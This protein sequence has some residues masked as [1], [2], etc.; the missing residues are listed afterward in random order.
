MTTPVVD[1]FFFSKCIASGFAL[2]SNSRLPNPSTTGDV[3][4]FVLINQRRSLQSLN[5][6]RAANYLKVMSVFFIGACAGPKAILPTSCGRH[7]GQAS[8]SWCTT[9]A[10]TL[11]S[12][13]RCVGTAPGAI[14]GAAR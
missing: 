13:R 5:Q 1:A 9:R 8:S 4:M 11:I 10:N 3:Q 12:A 6:T 2:A 7:D 14:A